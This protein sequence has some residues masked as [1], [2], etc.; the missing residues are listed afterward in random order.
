MPGSFQLS[1]QRGQMV[2]ECFEIE[3]A[4]VIIGRDPACDFVVDDPLVSR[5]HAQVTKAND[6]FTIQDLGSTN[7]TF[8]N[9]VQVTAPV[10]LKQGD[11][12]NLGKN[13]TL[14]FEP[15]DGANITLL[16]IDKAR[17]A[18]HVAEITNDAYF[19]DLQKMAKQIRRGKGSS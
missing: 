9:D 18:A 4:T 1:V 5:R 7:R 17:K 10:V 16:A 2:G 11:V 8:V 15:T 3:Q 19:Q 14:C 6:T 13:V 12:I